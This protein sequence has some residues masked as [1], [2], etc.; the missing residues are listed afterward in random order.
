VNYQEYAPS[1]ALRP[2]VERLW[3]LEAPA[4]AADAEPVLP[5]GHVEIIVHAGDPFDEVNPDGTRHRQAPVLLAGQLTQSKRIAP[6]GVARVAGARLRPNGAHALFDLPQHGVT[7]RVVDLTD[8]HVRAARMLRDDVTGRTDA[9]SLALALDRTLC[10]LAPASAPPSTIQWALD[11]ALDRHGLIQ[12]QD[13]SRITGVSDRQLQRAFHDEVGI[14]PKQL[15]RTLRFQEVLRRIRGQIDDVRW[16]EIA[17][18]C[19]FYDQAH[20]VHDFRSFTG[21][22]P[23]AWSIDD[24]SLT[25]IFSALR[26]A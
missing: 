23:G 12:V 14:S 3:V 2:F 1:L 11:L 25:A 15:L 4:G 7:N 8:I 10:R 26:R 17:A 24:A 13:L 6:G 22:S 5:D 21:E 16:T 18:S 19:G 9:R 20:F